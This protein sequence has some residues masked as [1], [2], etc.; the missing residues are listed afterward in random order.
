M[1]TYTI[2]SDAVK[3]IE[4]LRFEII[5]LKQQAKRMIEFD[6]F[7][8]LQRMIKDIKLKQQQQQNAYNFI[9]N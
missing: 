3:D 5:Q 7:K 2:K 9:K 1:K 4:K 6:Q 8:D